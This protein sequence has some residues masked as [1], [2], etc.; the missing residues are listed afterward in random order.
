MLRRAVL[1][2][3][4]IVLA[5]L[6]MAPGAQAKVAWSKCFGGPYQCG[7]VQVPLDYDT[8][9]GTQIQIA[10]IRLPATDPAHRIGSLF[11][12]PG[13]PG[14]SG[15]AQVFFDGPHLFTDE[16]RARYDLVGFDP[17]GVGNSSAL[18]CFGNF[19]QLPFPPVPFPITPEETAAWIDADH[20]LDDACARRAGRIVSHMSTANVARDMDRLRA[21]VGDARMHY[22][23]VSYGSYLGTTY[24][25]LFPDRVGRM[26]VD[27]VLDP[28]AWSTGAP[29]TGFTVPFSTRVGSGAGTYAALQE[30]F[31]LCDAAGDACAFSGGAAARYAALAEKLKTAPI[32]FVFPDGT[33]GELDYANLVGLSLGAMY[34]SPDWPFFAEGL[35]AAESAAPAATLGARLGRFAGRPAWIARRGEPRYFNF[36]EN[37]PA[38][39]CADSDNPG[40]YAAWISVSA[41]QDIAAP[42]FGRPW[43]WFSS[44]CADWPFTDTDRYMGP[45]A[46]NTAS[47]MLVVGNTT[48][49]AT[50]LHGAQTVNSLLAGS[51]LLTVHAWGHTSLFLSSCADAAIGAYLVNGT[52]PA[53][54]TVCEQDAPIFSQ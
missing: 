26:V 25:N 40:D 41:A 14:G 50:P 21:A 49:P 18:R 5:A 7:L 13:G 15:I 47:P 24:A 9:G 52:L 43:T 6:V 44:T 10:M 12:N 37:F 38:I 28:I 48:D 33:E 20:A 34:Y 4:S 53:P 17:R 35:A 22:N 19:R 1:T 8:P 31:R 3:L 42:Y 46:T 30:F 39:A 23:G 45:F 16:V 27:G 36:F 51:R 54:G 2:G 32:P 29:G 11:L